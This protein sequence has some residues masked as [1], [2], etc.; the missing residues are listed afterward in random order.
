MYL[1]D[2]D[3]SRRMYKYKNFFYPNVL[4]IH[5]HNRESYRTLKMTFIHIISAIKYFNKWH[6]FFDKERKKINNSIIEKY[7]KGIL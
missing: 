1:E 2:V 6:W 4:A 5:K 3:L 7:K